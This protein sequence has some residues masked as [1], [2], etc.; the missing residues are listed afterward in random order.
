M[1]FSDEILCAYLDGELGEE[2]RRAVESALNADHHLARRL[3][4]LRSLRAG[5]VSAQ[6]PNAGARQ[7]HATVVQL[8]A[9]RASRAASLVAARKAQRTGWG[10][11]EWGALA[12]VLVAGVMLGRFVL[13]RWQPGWMAEPPPTSVIVSREGLLVAQGRLAWALSQQMGGAMPVEHE[14]RVGLSF[15][16]NDGSYC[17]TFTLAGSGQEVN[18]IACRISDE[19]RIPVVVQNGRG[20]TAGR[21]G[22]VE[23]PTALLEAIDQRIVGGMLDARAEMEALKRGWQ[24]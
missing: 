13:A 19:W 9:V 11:R 16:A 1:S 17:R 24:R 20:L 6:S 22:G 2:T 10:W 18:G 4:R 12:L 21:K 15:L 23:M 14:A 8:D 3:A 7:G 5:R